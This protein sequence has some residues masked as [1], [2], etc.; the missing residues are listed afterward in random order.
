MH[1]IEGVSYTGFRNWGI[2]INGE[3][4]QKQKRHSFMDDS[5]TNSSSLSYNNK[6]FNKCLF[7]HSLCTLLSGN[8]IDFNL[9]PPHNDDIDY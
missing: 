4:I 8:L 5:L 3:Q 7:N 6:E 2:K 1:V 9:L